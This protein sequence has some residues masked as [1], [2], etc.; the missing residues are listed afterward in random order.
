MN[1]FRSQKPTLHASRWY[2]DK[3]LN[4]AS[5][6]PS[7]PPR[8]FSQLVIWRLLEVCPWIPERDPS[9]AAHMAFFQINADLL[10]LR[11][12]MGVAAG[13]DNFDLK[14]ATSPRSVLCAEIA[15]HGESHTGGP[16]EGAPSPLFE[17]LNAYLAQ[18]KV[19]TRESVN[20]ML[21]E[22]TRRDEERRGVA[23][24]SAATAGAADP[25]ARQ[26]LPA[27]A[28]ALPEGGA[29]DFWQRKITPAAKEA[30]VS[31]P[32]GAALGLSALSS[33]STGAI[34]AFEADTL[35]CALREAVDSQGAPRQD[36]IVVACLIDR[37]PNL[38]GLARTC[39][40]FS[41]SRLVLADTSVTSHPDFSSIS[42]S[43]E[44]WVPLEE[45]PP[46]ALLPWLQRK[47]AEGYALVG[48]E[49]TAESTRLPEFAFPKKTVLVL[50]AEKE[51]VPADVLALLHA[52]VEIPQLG[53]VRS[54]NVHVSA[55]I[56][57]YEYTRQALLNAQ[58]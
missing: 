7:R 18:E 8:T 50:G 57:I 16:L 49:Q 31:D 26:S 2:F 48:L 21:A 47:A 46:A 32:W 14:K 23:A 30:A 52:T 55:A 22:S 34:D 38:A 13:L 54:L 24:A 45:V 20:D 37:L 12:A 11:A 40:V 42:V 25:K 9:L 51:G 44:H 5:L 27:T 58:H 56:G 28:T 17:R 15:L 10:R 6:S 53:V 43:A 35:R 33:R 36:I 29:S 1:S 39:E 3:A 4:G 41:A 19:A